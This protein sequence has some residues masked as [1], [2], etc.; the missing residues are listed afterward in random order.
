[1][2]AIAAA[3]GIFMIFAGFS[4]LSS[5][6]EWDRS[7]GDYSLFG[8]SALALVFIAWQLFIIR[9]PRP[10]L[11]FVVG[12]AAIFHTPGPSRYVRWDEVVSIDV[13]QVSKSGRDIVFTCQRS[14]DRDDDSDKRFHERVSLSGGILT[15]DPDLVAAR[16]NG[17]IRRGLG[18][19]FG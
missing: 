12:G 11:E 19:H 8:F 7:A 3:F 13:R 5:R 14:P 1:M 18:T 10:A 16:L 6:P 9:D 2:I 15:Q 17:L 4:V